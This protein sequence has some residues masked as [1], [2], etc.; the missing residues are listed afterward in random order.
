[1][2]AKAI[3]RKEWGTVVD[4]IRAYGSYKDS[5][6]GRRKVLEDAGSRIDQKAEYVIISGCRQP[7]DMP[8]V[9]SDFSAL[10]NRLQVDYTFLS[11]EFCCGWIPLQQPAVMAKDDETIAKAKALVKEFILGNFR[12]AEALGAKS[13]ALFCTACESNY[14]NYQSETDLELIFYTELLDRYFQ[15]GHLAL[16]ADYYEGCYRF[17]RRITDQPLNTEPAVRVLSKIEGLRLHRLD[18]KLCCYIPPH[19][20]QLTASIRSKTVIT[21]CTGCYSNLRRVE[22]GNYQVR[23]LPEVVLEALQD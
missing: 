10:L 4:N 7:E 19:F 3:S 5:G 17:R 9:F 1:M 8:H 2:C 15:Y 23:M 11:K 18:S 16:D 14:S 22:R 6:E 12:Q 20:E 21:I 13:I